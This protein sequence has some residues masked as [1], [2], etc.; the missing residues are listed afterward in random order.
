MPFLLGI[1][2]SSYLF[3]KRG[4]RH[5]LDETGLFQLFAIDRMSSYSQIYYVPNCSAPGSFSHLTELL[6]NPEQLGT[7]IFDQQQYAMAAKECLQLYLCSHRNFSNLKEATR[8]T[9]HDKTMRRNKPWEWVARLRLGVHSRIWKARHHFKVQKFKSLET[10]PNCQHQYISLPKNSPKR[11]YFQ[12]LSYRWA[13]DLLPLLLGKSAVSLELADVLHG[14]T[15]T[16]MAWEFPRS[17]RLAKEAIAR[18]LLR[19]ESVVGKA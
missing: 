19:V 14:C 7:H 11:Q 17:M 5:I 10:Q 4:D 15:F 6:E 18:Y 12:F 9:C 8:F 16:M 3:R 13:L 2:A 1:V